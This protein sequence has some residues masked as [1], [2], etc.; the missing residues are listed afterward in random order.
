MKFKN[1]NLKLS[2][3]CIKVTLINFSLTFRFDISKGEQQNFDNFTNQKLKRINEKRL[4]LSSQFLS[5]YFSYFVCWD[6]RER[7]RER[8]G[9]GGWPA[10]WASLLSHNFP[11]LSLVLS[12][13]LIWQI[14]PVLSNFFIFPKCKVKLF[15]GLIF[16]QQLS[17]DKLSVCFW[18]YRG[19]RPWPGQDKT[20]STTNMFQTEVFRCW[21]GQARPTFSKLHWFSHTK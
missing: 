2:L 3:S 18:S 19:G 10:S 5:F 13:M 16:W 4:F 15:N 11:S 7:E 1:G 9:E 14:A 6:E 17:I 8:E 20:Q 21:R 12:P